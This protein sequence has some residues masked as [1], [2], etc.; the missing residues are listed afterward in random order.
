MESDFLFC[1]FFRFEWG[2]CPYQPKETPYTDSKRDN[3]QDCAQNIF[4]K[5][6]GNRYIQCA[7]DERHPKENEK[8]NNNT[9]EDG[10]SDPQETGP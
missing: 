5:L 9:K 7:K 1:F 10:S 4:G 3:E 8:S 2:S 6:H